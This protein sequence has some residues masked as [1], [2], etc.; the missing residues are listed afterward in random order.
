[1][2]S[3][4]APLRHTNA[5]WLSNGRSVLGGIRALRLGPKPCGRGLSCGHRADTEEDDEEDEE[6]N[7]NGGEEAEDNT[8]GGAT[9]FST[10]IETSPETQTEEPSNTSVLPKC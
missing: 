5:G 10:A 6:G 9:G 3:D 1:M 2:H 8:G 7:E 4:S